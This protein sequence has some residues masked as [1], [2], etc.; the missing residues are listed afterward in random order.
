MRQKFQKLGST[1]FCTSLVINSG[2][3]KKNITLK[4]L[5]YLVFLFGLFNITVPFSKY[6]NITI[7]SDQLDHILRKCI[8][9]SILNP[10][11]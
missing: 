8:L 9:F 2:S 10:G 11:V 4:I 6:L 7:P 3:E 5:F 1:T